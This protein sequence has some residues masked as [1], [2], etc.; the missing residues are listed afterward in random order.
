MTTSYIGLF[1]ILN[2]HIFKRPEVGP[3][4]YNIHSAVRNPPRILL[5][6]NE[7]RNGLEKFG[8]NDA[9][10]STHIVWF[11][12]QTVIER[13]PTSQTIVLPKVIDLNYMW[14]TEYFHFMTEVLPNALFLVNSG[15][16]YPIFCR[17]SAFTI[18]AFEWFGITNQIV[19]SYAPIKAVHVVPPYVECGNPSYQK[20]RLLRNV[21]ESKV[22]FES[23]HGIL[24]R[25]HGSRELL[26]ESDVLAFFQLKY[27][28]LTW[29]IFDT[30]S[31][32]ETASLFSKAAKIVGPHGAGMTNMLFAPTGVD[33]LE[34]MPV[35]DPNLC[36]WHLSEM[37]GHSYT[38]FP[39][40]CNQTN[41]MSIDL[42]ELTELYRSKE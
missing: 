17:A 42:N 28:E 22:Q 27:P 20:V 25:R 10:Y 2:P 32:E 14:A 15:F 33:I 3:R 38:M 16:H 30:L 24:I 7:V 31:I 21:I 18:P 41:S 8:N 11:P 40:P 35:S 5:R 1:A 13:H 9:F 29:V 37:L 36:Y 26:N 4:P 12:N 34:F 19:S 6:E 39:A 23:T